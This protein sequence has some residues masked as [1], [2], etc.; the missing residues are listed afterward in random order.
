MWIQTPHC[1]VDPL[2]VVDCLSAFLQFGLPANFLLSHSSFLKHSFGF[3]DNLYT[4]FS[5]CLL[6]HL[7]F[8]SLGHS[9]SSSTQ[10]FSF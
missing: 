6:G 8:V 5:F 2:L 9:S 1:R 10:T 3:H 4:W 7:L